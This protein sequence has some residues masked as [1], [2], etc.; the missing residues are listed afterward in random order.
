MSGSFWQTRLDGKD[1]AAA[2]RRHQNAYLAGR[3]QTPCEN[4]VRL[5]RSLFHGNGEPL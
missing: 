1:R 5:E 4:R 2:R 3:L